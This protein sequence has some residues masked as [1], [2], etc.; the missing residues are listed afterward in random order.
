MHDVSLGRTIEDYLTGEDVEETTYEDLRQALARI[1]VEEKGYPRELLKPRVAVNVTIQGKSYARLADIAAFDEDGRVLMILIFCP[2]CISTFTR[3]ARAAARL[4]EGG[5]APLY[6]VTDSKD[7]RLHA[8]QSD[9][10][11]AEGMGAIPYWERLL[12][13]AAANPAAPLSEER[14]E[15]EGRILYCY[16]E[17]LYACCNMASCVISAK[18]GGFKE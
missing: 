11:L 5:P 12:E 15:K 14:A 17:S 1:L 18:G 6:V 8:T 10:L 16:S 7:A 4:I 13:L 2:G 9:E 3:E